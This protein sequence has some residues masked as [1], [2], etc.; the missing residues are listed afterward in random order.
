MLLAL[1][2]TLLIVSNVAWA[3]RY[4]RQRRLIRHL[5]Q[6]MMAGETA[7]RANTQKIIDAPVVMRLHLDQDR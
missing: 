6:L 7:R 1:V 3:W 5:D 2:V 4:G